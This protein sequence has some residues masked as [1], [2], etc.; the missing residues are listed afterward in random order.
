MEVCHGKSRQKHTDTIRKVLECYRLCV[1]C[2]AEC[3]EQRKSELNEC[4]KLCE[5][6]AGF[7]GVCA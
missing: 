7:C 1:L 6:C 3:L 5:I 4:I 2:A